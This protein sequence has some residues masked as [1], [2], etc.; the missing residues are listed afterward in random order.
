MI[1][2]VAH[3]LTKTYPRNEDYS[4][5]ALPQNGHKWQKPQCPPASLPSVDIL[6]RSGQLD[7]PL[8]SRP[9]QLDKAEARGEDEKT[10]D[11]G[12]D[13][14]PES[15]AEAE[16][17]SEGLHMGERGKKEYAKGSV[18]MIRMRMR[19]NKETGSDLEE[20]EDGNCADEKGK[21]EPTRCS[22]PDLGKSTRC[23]SA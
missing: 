12:E 4:F 6:E 23:E 9:I 11:D 1:E 20:D 7:T 16:G 14:L 19:M 17:R 21:P 22:E 18:R 15:L 10:G 8:D 5:Q 2:G 13:A 3:N